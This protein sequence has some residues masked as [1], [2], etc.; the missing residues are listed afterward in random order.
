MMTAVPV[1]GTWYSCVV[2][3]RRH[4]RFEG[5]SAVA[6]CLMPGQ[7]RVVV[8]GAG[9][10]GLSTACCLAKEGWHVTV[11]EKN[12]Q[13][14]GRCRVWEKDG[15]VFDM[16]PSWYWMPEVFEKFF[17][18]FGRKVSDY[19]SLQ[20]LDPP[21]KVFFQDGKEVSV[22]DKMGELEQLFEKRETGAAAKLKM[23]LAQAAYKYKVG[24]ESY[25]WKPSVAWSEFLD[26]RL[27]V[28]VLRL[29]MLSSQRSHVK[30][31]FKDPTL[32]QLM[33][34]PVLFLGGSPQNIPAMYSMMNH[35]AIV[36]G[37]WWPK[38][39][40]AEVPKAMVSLARELGVEFRTGKSGT[41][42]QIVVDKPSGRWFKDAAQCRAVAVEEGD[43]VPADVVVGAADY[44]HVEQRLLE[45]RW[46]SYSENYWEQRVMSPSSLLFYI[47]LNCRVPNL[48][49]HNL[50]F[51]EDIDT[52]VEEIYSD[53][54][55]PSKPLFY[56]SVT[57]LT[58]PGM[59]PKG[60]DSLFLLVP[61]AATPNI[62]TPE[63][64]AAT[65]LVQ[66]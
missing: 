8:I 50:F 16:G 64:C 34:W 24:M 14:G 55:W 22:P 15:Y 29:Q 32:V 18:H 44:H 53:P 33:E 49:H 20:R 42:T 10:A 26:P 27:L 25:V 7:K 4:F 12:D 40:M 21:Y 28:E 52:H 61:L 13:L 41:A 62:D 6:H 63:R 48:E 1:L 59:A 56:A 17:A 38:G 47:G 36:G 58:E 23:F 11:L 43:D 39:G 3:S 30:A 37:T 5:L 60:C 51:D 2:Q 46:R 31:H 54:A 45:P 57:T 66:M 35:A 65:P 19:Y 9:F